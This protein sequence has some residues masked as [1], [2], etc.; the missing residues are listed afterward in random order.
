MRVL[1]R[2]KLMVLGLG[3]TT[4]GI[5]SCR[6]VQPVVSSVL[7]TDSLITTYKQ[8]SLLIKGAKVEERLDLDSLILVARSV[9]AAYLKDSVLAVREGREVVRTMSTAIRE[10]TDPSTKAALSYWIDEYGRLNIG[11]ESKDQTIQLL[12]AQVKQL[13]KEITTAQ[14]IEYKT[15]W[16]NYLIIL[17]LLAALLLTIIKK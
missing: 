2:K 10:F 3:V 5:L 9:R 12:I 6:S 13:Q 16:Y 4:L 11:C 8:E 15:P 17:T 7:K 14:K 1:T